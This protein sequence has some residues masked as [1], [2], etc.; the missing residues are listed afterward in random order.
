[1]NQQEE[2]GVEPSPQQ[3]RET[4]DQR[5]RP[6][7]LRGMIE[8]AAAFLVGK[9]LGALLCAVFGFI[10]GVLSRIGAAWIARRW[11]VRSDAAKAAR[12]MVAAAVAA[13]KPPAKLLGPVELDALRCTMSD[14]K[15]RR[16]D[17]AL[18]NYQGH[19]RDQMQRPG[20]K[21]DDPIPRNAAALNAAAKA[22]LAA[23][24]KP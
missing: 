13:A 7:G 11:L 10:C 24:P 14:R 8:S 2:H 12:A 6:P 23:L 18:A 15:W 21:F 20:A 19:H 17:A 5:H 22:V 1:M 4:E 9:P 16:L 3:E